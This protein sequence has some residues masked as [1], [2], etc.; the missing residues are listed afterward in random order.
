MAKKLK[1]EDD[2]NAFDNLLQLVNN[3]HNE[4]EQIQK[5]SDNPY[6]K[7]LTV[8]ILIKTKPM[9]DKLKLNISKL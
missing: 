3:F 1:T 5:E 7:R 8:D 4:V 2:V 9:K 6:L